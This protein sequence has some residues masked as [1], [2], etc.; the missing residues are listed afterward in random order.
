[1]EKIR[2]RGHRSTSA[3][4][5]TLARPPRP[6]GLRAHTVGVVLGSVDTPTFLM[7]RWIALLHVVA[8][9]LL[10]TLGLEDI[11][12]G[13]PTRPMLIPAA[14]TYM[15]AAV[16]F[17]VVMRERSPRVLAWILGLSDAV[18]FTAISYLTVFNIAGGP[19]ITA[20]CI[21]LVIAILY[22][23]YGNTRLSLVLGCLLVM[24]YVIPLAADVVTIDQH[25]VQSSSAPL[26]AGLLIVLG[27]A[28]GYGLAR[29]QKIA[30]I[31][32]VLTRLD[33]IGNSIMYHK[34]TRG[35]ADL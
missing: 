1:M 16:V 3:G 32:G 6:S 10:M 34:L 9:F 17:Y 12:N 29:Q 33:H 31:A 26:S 21:A 11:V 35:S 19:D 24:A 23:G 14:G 13:G 22:A 25:V 27:A 30:A 8:G 5:P 7:N 20:A 2:A 28:I 18:L 15:A 4:G